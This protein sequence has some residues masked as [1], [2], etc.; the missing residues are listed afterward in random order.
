M[1]NKRVTPN[2]YN[3]SNGSCDPLSDSVG[4][5][6]SCKNAVLLLSEMD[7]NGFPPNNPYYKK[8]DDLG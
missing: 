2:K 3:H 4:D 7:N 6:C 5:Q 8:P 1:D